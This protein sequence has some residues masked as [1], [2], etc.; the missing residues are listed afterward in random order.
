M[1]ETNGTDRPGPVRID[2]ALLSILA[3][4]GCHGTVELRG[5]ALH[6]TRCGRRYPVRD[7]IP[8][9]LVDQ[10]LPPEQSAPD[11]G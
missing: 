8:V 4:P 11:S 2:A 9:M 3:C 7:G 5:A 10:T 6:C 1:A